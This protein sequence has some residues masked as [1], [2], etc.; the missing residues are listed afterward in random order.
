MESYEQGYH[1]CAL[2]FAEISANSGATVPLVQIIVVFRSPH[3]NNQDYRSAILYSLELYSES[4]PSVKESMATSCDREQSVLGYT[5]P[6]RNRGSD[7][8]GVVLGLFQL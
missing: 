8:K 7:S 2:I 6:G 4:D 1:L 5:G 3:E